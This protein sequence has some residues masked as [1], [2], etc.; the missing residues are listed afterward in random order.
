MVS[1]ADPSPNDDLPPA[2]V[3]RLTDRLGRLPVKRI[4]S[5]AD[6]YALRSIEIAHVSRLAR[7]FELTGEQHAFVESWWR[8]RVD[9]RLADTLA[10]IHDEESSR[11]HRSTLRFLTAHRSS[12]L[13]R[14]LQN[15]L[16]QLKFNTY[17]PGGRAWFGNRYVTLRRY[18]FRL[19]W[20]A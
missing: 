12:N 20:R 6:Y 7:E 2:L 10:P 13:P 15:A 17:G 4:R 9:D 5:T 3:R 8:E 19:H 16:W 18:T 11:S 1:A 14:P